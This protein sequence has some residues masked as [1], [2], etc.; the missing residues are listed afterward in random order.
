MFANE[1]PKVDTDSHKSNSGPHGCKANTPSQPQT[2]HS[3]V[4]HVNKDSFLLFNK[5]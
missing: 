3:K 2:S 4:C 5:S 1:D